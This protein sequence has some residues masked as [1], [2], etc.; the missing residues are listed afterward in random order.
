MYLFGFPEGLAGGSKETEYLTNFDTSH[1]TV[2]STTGS[3]SYGTTRNTNRTTS[4]T[5]LFAWYEGLNKSYYL[6]NN[7]CYFEVR[8]TDVVIRAK[9]AR[10]WYGG[11]DGTNVLW[12]VV[13]HTEVH[14]L[15]GLAPAPPNGYNPQA[16]Q[17][18]WF[19]SAEW[20]NTIYIGAYRNTAYNNYRYDL[21]VSSGSGSKIIGFNSTIQG[22]ES[23]KTLS[24]IADV[25]RG[26]ETRYYWAG[27]WWRTTTHQTSRSTAIATD[28]DTIYQTNQL[29]S[30]ITYG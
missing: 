24:R 29:T 12:D 5:M 14:D 21:L 13:D 15:K 4:R 18:K 9:I 7:H 20:G 1:S 19:N 25:A 26:Q 3:T 2:G 8:S 17:N 22:Y 23:L 6:Q 28:V 27:T 16:N 10:G 30:R 11:T